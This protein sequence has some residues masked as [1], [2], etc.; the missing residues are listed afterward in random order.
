MNRAEK[1]FGPDIGTMKGK[2]MRSQLTPVKRDEIEIPSK[3][4]EKNQKIVLCMDIMFMNRMPIQ[5]SIDQTIR[6]RLLVPIKSRTLE[7]LYR[8]INIIVRN[9]NKAGSQLTQF[10]VMEN[11]ES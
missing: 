4:T 11:S 7:E 9:C 6:F 3:L 2:N 1:I 8:G 5:T 10:T